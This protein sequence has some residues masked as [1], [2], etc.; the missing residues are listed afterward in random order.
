M[1]KYDAI[2]VGGG[3]AGL[4]GAIALARSRRKVLVVDEGNPRNAVSAHAHNVLGHEGISPHK[5]LELGRAEATDYGVEFASARIESLS[6]SL[7]EGFIISTQ[8]SQWQA[9][10][11]LLA[12]GL[13]DALPE[14]PGL[15]KAWGTSAL[16]CPYCHGWEVRDQQI[17]IL[18]VSEMST[19]QA[20]LF[21]QLSDT[22]TYVNHAPKSLTAENRAL[23]AAVGIE[24]VDAQVTDI[25]VSDDGQVQSLAL[26]NGSTLG[27][28][29]VVVASQMKANAS[30][31]LGL[32]GDLSQ[33]P[34]GEFISVNEMGATSV[35]GVYAAGNI[36]NLGAMIGL[37]TAA[38]T[39]AG[40]AI[41]A[42]LVM[43]S[44]KK[45]LARK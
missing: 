29:A 21:R 44:A 13:S 10:R 1:E 20:L 28:Q 25:A 8:A 4:A 43:E 32:G 30:L 17:A 6:G 3:N 41:N 37:A 38:G 19:H 7:E 22:I 36:S 42:D 40:A 31:F 45:K 5:L 23:L 11:I 27:A 26:N 33:N 15:Q 35:P 2:I 12:T 14:I 24:V 34:M 9:E 16:H 39:M 18:G